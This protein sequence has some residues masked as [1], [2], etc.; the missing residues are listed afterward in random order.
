MKM[1]PLRG[2]VFM[3]SCRRAFGAKRLRCAENRSLRVCIHSST[4]Y[5]VYTRGEG[6]NERRRRRRTAVL[7]AILCCVLLYCVTADYLYA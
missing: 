6:Q 2:T 3:H 1:L 7:R 4:R 5:Y